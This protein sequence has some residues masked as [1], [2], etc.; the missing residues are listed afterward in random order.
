MKK[1]GPPATNLPSVNEA[2]AFVENANV[3]V[4]GFFKDQSSD[5]AKAFL[6]VAS[7]IDDIPFG[8]SESDE[9]SS[10]YQIQDGSV[11][12]FKKVSIILDLI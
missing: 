4:I 12:L 8:I 9:V 6:A 2:K 11:V 7:G 1:T 5:L 10:N 3:V